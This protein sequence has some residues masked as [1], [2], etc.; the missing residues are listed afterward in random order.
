MTSP[1]IQTAF[2]TGEISPSLFGHVDL[3]KSHV[4]A[5]TM[6][7]AWVNYRG[8]AYSRAGTAFCNWS[9]QVFG[10][11]P[12]RVITF[13]FNIDQ[14]FCL[15]FGTEY[16]RVFSD[17]SPVT[18]APKNITGATQANPTQLTILANGYSNGDWIAI[19]GVGGMTELNGNVYIVQGATT[20]TVTLTD[21]FGNAINSTTFGAYTSGGTASRIYTLVTP[22]QAADLPLLKFTQSADTMSLVHPNYAPRDLARITDSE[23]VLTVA[24]FASSIAA[25][26]S[27]TATAT[28]HPSQTTSPVTLPTAYA[29]VVTSVNGATGEES[30]ASPVANVTNSVDIA[31]TAGSLVINWSAV[32]GASRYNIYKAPASYNTAP[33]NTANAL[34]VPAGA[35]FG[36]MATSYGTQTVDSNITPD[37]TQS[38]PLHLDPFAP[39]QIL[40]VNVS[41]GGSGLSS[42][43]I[44]ITTS[45][46]SGFVGLPIIVNGVLTAVQVQDPGQYY[47]PTDSVSFGGPGAYA[48]GDITFTNN[49]SNLD[50]IT[51]NGQVWTFVT[52]SPGANQTLIGT[53]LVSTLTLLVSG[54][55]ASLD[56][57]L[58][59]ANYSS[60][61]AQLLITYD[62]PG[63][64]GN[65]YTLA[66]SVATPS[67]STLTG[68]GTGTNPTGTLDVGPETGTYPGVVAYFQQRRVYANT[69]NNPD[70]YYMSQPGAFLNFDSSVPTTDADAIT[71]TP[72]A[73]QVNG[74]SFMIQMPAGLV[75][76]TGSGVWVVNGTGGSTINPQPVTPTSQQALQANFIGSNNICPPFVENYDIIYV[77]S[78]G[79]IVRDIFTGSYFNIFQSNDLTQLSS[80]LFTAYT[81]S[82]VAWTEEPYKVAWYVRN[83]G[84]MLSL[85]YLKEQEVYGW[86]RHDT[87][88]WFISNCSVTEPPVDALYVAVQRRVPANNGEPAYFIERMNNRIWQS[89]EDAWCVDCAISLPQAVQESVIITT[90]VTGH[91]TFITTSPTFSPGNIGA[92]IRVGG[93]IAEITGYV[94]ATQ[95]TGTWYLPPAK[96]Y[97]DTESPSLCQLAGSWTITQPVTSIGGLGYLAGQTV[98]GLAD[99]VV[100][101]PVVVPS[102]GV[103]DLPFAASNVVVGL[104]F[105]VQIQSP[106]LDMQAQATVQGR[107]K[108]ITALTT[109]VDTSLG[110][111]TGTNEVDGS[112]VSPPVL[113]PVWTNLQPAQ[114]LSATYT[115]P[116]GATVTK[117]WTGDLRDPQVANWAKPGQVAAQ[118]NQPFPLS[119]TAFMP[120]TLE[121]DLVEMSYA[122]QQ[123]RDPKDA[124]RGPGAWM[125]RA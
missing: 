77:Q 24:S 113:A 10:N 122:P 28:T 108:T 18:E 117:L 80:H 76:L 19:S 83:D 111:E 74:I 84:S 27:C 94:S 32:P 89:V 85:T 63:T 102:N 92:I 13:Q 107:R 104:P 9:K 101:P 34:P 8:G 14:G 96:V 68:G 57:D 110:F 72:W 20:N 25:P 26:A 81:L 54:L 86:A 17:G 62:T 45:T 99:G 121:G 67:G 39:G 49:P 40:A 120:E 43:T 53:S 116:G 61:G 2:A 71:G 23:W 16:M 35:L 125:L 4:S 90:Q 95:V 44:I 112:T 119:V 3:A 1:S 38:P 66:A 106:Y 78:K 51:L 42:V 55:S 73:Q 103:I 36:Y 118:Q 69:T 31:S 30:V 115:S 79:S 7:N 100:I 109:R 56:A 47:A 114:T 105:G 70:T 22:Y 15:E 46:G 5:A 98:T 64:A 41:S 58:I 75:V 6:R 123:A 93:G 97:V 29:Y 59:V 12:P 124:P 50:T 33:G 82:S 21:V 11:G 37:L 65:S 91:A 87:Y 88:G 60:N 48:T 52:S